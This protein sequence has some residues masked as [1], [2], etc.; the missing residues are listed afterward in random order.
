VARLEC[1]M[2]VALGQR[3]GRGPRGVAIT[4]SGRDK[5]LILKVIKASA[6]HWTRGI[7]KS[8]LLGL[9]SRCLVLR[10]ECFD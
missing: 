9:R 2:Q 3:A 1:S 6:S 10:T 5:L 4:G 8:G 7:N